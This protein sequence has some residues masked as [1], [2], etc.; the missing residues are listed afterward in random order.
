MKKETEKLVKDLTWTYPH[1][2]RE[3]RQQIDKANEFAKGY[4]LFLDKGKTERECVSF[5]LNLLKNIG[6]EDISEGIRINGAH[7]D[8]PRLDLKPNPLYERDEIAYFKTHYY[9]GIRKYQWGTIPL[10]LHGVIVKKDGTSVE[11]NIGENEEEPV[12]YIS[13]LL[14]HLSA[15]QNERKLSE[16]LK[17]EELNIILGTLPFDDEDVKEPFKLYILSILNEIWYK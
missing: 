7:I 8:S 12:F 13:D 9:G 10:A 5:A 1:I 14:P 3:D 16:G 11:I 17:G 4:K 2:A 15:V 6:T